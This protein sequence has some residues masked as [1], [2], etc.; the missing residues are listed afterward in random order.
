MVVKKS[1]KD[2]ETTE[3]KEMEQRKK[4]F[5]G[6]T[7]REWTLLSRNVWND[8]SSPRRAHQLEHGAVYPEKLTERII[9]MYSR[10]GDLVFDPFLGSGTTVISA[11]KCNRS[12]IGIELSPRF[13][14]LSKDWLSKTKGPLFNTSEKETKHQIIL[15]DCR[16]MKKYIKDHSVQ[17]TVTSPPYA[18]FIQK[19]LADRKKTHKKSKLVLENNSVVKQYSNV[20]EDFGN[21]DYKDFL[22]EITAVLKANLEITK[23]G[24]YS[25]WIVKD[26]RDTKNSVPYID[27]H[28]DLA[29]VGQKI[30]WK[31]HDLIVW[32]Q[33][34][35][36]SLVL[37][38]YPSV[39][40]SNQNCSFIVVFRK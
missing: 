7:A 16:N 37:L 30:G 22:K 10:E 24:G 13:F 20:L 29:H 12:A 19:S 32:D 8:L 38:G 14:D 21:L 9:K 2:P 3:S 1:T 35:Q 25:V 4:S 28:S 31:Y 26:Y 36:R 18:N 15:D 40:Y 5:N 6:L 23:N 11:Y 39:F 27:F 17:L 33:N 34:E